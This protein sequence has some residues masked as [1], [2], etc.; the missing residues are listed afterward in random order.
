MLNFKLLHPLTTNN[1]SSIKTF[2]Y[3]SFSLVKQYNIMF[4]KGLMILFLS[5]ITI[6]LNFCISSIPSS[7]KSLPLEGHFSFDEFDLKKAARDFGNRYQ[8]F[9][10]TV[11]HPKSVSDIS[12]TIKHVWNLGPNS[13]LTVA[14]RGHGHSLQGQA[15]AH[16]GVVINMESLNKVDE[17]KV[18]AGGE[19]A[20]VDVSGGELWIKILHETLKY[21]L[22][23]RSW[24]DYLHLTVGGTL[25][26]AGVSGQAFRHGPQISNV[27]KMEI[28]TGW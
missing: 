20:Y 27:L 16:G 4:I 21:G 13:Q 28:V 22:A 5:C 19:F 1:I 8:S 3:P 14:A 2:R 18:Y 24:T 12:V 10:M 7:L 15:Q 11:L 23:P 25:S 9:P 6:R 26:N 17:M